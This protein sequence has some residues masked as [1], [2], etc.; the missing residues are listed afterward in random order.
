[1]T[2]K[3]AHLPAR[4]VRYLEAG[5]GTPLVLL[6]AFPLHA[7]QW[8]PQID[9]PPRG[10]RVIA[11]DLRGWGPG[12][13][14]ALA[15]PDTIDGHADDILELLAH[16][17]LARVVIGGL[18]MGGY[19]ALALAAK[20]SSRVAGLVLADTRASADTAEGRAKRDRTIARVAKDGPV[21]VARDLA[22]G[23]VGA[24]T[25]AEQPDLVDVLDDFARAATRD[26]LTSTIR[27]LRDRPD[28]TPLLGS[29]A[30]PTLVICGDEDTITPPPASEALHAAIAG[31]R[32][33]MIPRAGHLSN[34]EQPAAFNAALGTW[35]A[36]VSLRP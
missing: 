26:G 16:L 10:W 2:S 17:D 24:T 31:S 20:A 3:V 23:L 8:L 14:N 9:R 29:I 28:R 1:V 19:V 22:S 11:P 6:H 18:S 35:A 15:I 5:S 33:V 21:A 13:A 7:N 30:C 27:A 4:S 36:S 32:L 12:A 34:L 25:R